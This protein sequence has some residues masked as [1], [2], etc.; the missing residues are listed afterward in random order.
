MFWECTCPKE[1][2]VVPPV[3]TMCTSARKFRKKIVV[4]G[5]IER[6]SLCKQKLG[7]GY[8]DIDHF[9][10]EVEADAFLGKIR[11]GEWKTD[12]WGGG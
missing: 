3:E 11:I 1:T 9:K 5:Y 7:D 10:T 4:T 8:G 6:C 12:E 2:G